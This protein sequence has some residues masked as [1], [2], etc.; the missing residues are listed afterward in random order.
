MSEYF[1]CSPRKGFKLIACTKALIPYFQVKCENGRYASYPILA[2]ESVVAV[3]RGRVTYLTELEYKER[4]GVFVSRRPS[5][6][7]VNYVV[8]RLRELLGMQEEVS[9]ELRKYPAFEVA[10]RRLSAKPFVVGK[11]F[12]GFKSESLFFKDSLTIILEP[13]KE[14]RRNA[15]SFV[16]EELPLKK[17]VEKIKVNGVTQEVSAYVP[18]SALK[19]L[20]NNPYA[21]LAVLVQTVGMSESEAREYL[22]KSFVP[23]A[24]LEH[25]V[26]VSRFLADVEETSKRQLTG[27]NKAR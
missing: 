10:Y 26:G 2:N 5:E 7:T 25:T 17:V 19:G 12:K 22:R 13:S 11:E 9:A 21:K 18:P 3:T 4:L 27:K 14:M 23:Y 15:L 8:K 16:S 6:Y 1:F 20:F 24:Y